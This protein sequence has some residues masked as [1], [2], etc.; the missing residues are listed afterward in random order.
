MTEQE[1]K[2]ILIQK[3]LS[4]LKNQYLSHPCYIYKI[5]NTVNQKMYIGLTTT[6]I[7]TRWKYHKKSAKKP[8][9]PLYYAMRKYGIDKFTI[10]IIEECILLN[11]Q[12]RE[13]YWIKY[14][15]TFLNKEK[16]YNQSPGGELSLITLQDELEIIKAY[17]EYGTIQKVS[18]ILNVDVGRIR[19]ILLKNGVRIKS[20][21]EHNKDKGFNVYQYD[22]NHNLI[23]IFES[24][25]EAGQW[26]LDNNLSNA[27]NRKN[28]CETIRIALASENNKAKGY[29]W[30]HDENYPESSK[31]SEINRVKKCKEK[32]KK[33]QKKEII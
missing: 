1:Q 14:Y 2:K 7:E 26:L 9:A 29:Y 32:N 21:Q 22:E 8:K 30:E 17:K 19:K 5:T 24:V 6:S 4:T 15:D 13:K 28:A 11:V 23:N 33:I 10:E 31:Q 3:L 20:A 16:G 18:N 25:Y 12:N 27:K